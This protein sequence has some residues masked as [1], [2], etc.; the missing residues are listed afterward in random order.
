MKNKA[1]IIGFA[2]ACLLI[3]AV[4]GMMTPWKAAAK[5]ATPQPVQQVDTATPVALKMWKN[6][7]TPF[8][9]GVVPNDTYEV[10]AGTY[11]TVI[12]IHNYSEKVATFVVKAVEAIPMGGSCAYGAISP[13]VI[14]WL[15][16]DASK[17]INEANIRLFLEEANAPFDGFVQIASTIPIDVS[18]IHTA[19]TTA[20]KTMDIERVPEVILPTPTAA[21]GAAV[22]IQ[23]SAGWFSDFYALSIG[24][25]GTGGIPIRFAPVNVSFTTNPALT[26]CGSTPVAEFPTLTTDCNG[27]VSIGFFS[28]GKDDY[29]ITIKSGTKIKG[30]IDIPTP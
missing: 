6:Y 15:P 3:I 14:G 11:R 4:V 18:A 1:M 21:S 13:W 8:V 25:K 29:Y 12:K 19:D 23:T 30:P 20:G 2:L 22:D 5:I 17:E 10:T 27:D 9:I 26:V 28:C 7:S 24:I 16:P